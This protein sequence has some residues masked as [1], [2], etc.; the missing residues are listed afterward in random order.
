MDPA[1]SDDLSSKIKSSNNKWREVWH[2]MRASP[3]DSH[4][5]ETQPDLVRSHQHALMCNLS[6]EKCTNRI[7]EIL[8]LKSHRMAKGRLGGGPVG[9]DHDNLFAAEPT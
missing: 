5:N 4:D 1:S 9:P 8:P 6:R 2:L 7:M 3:D